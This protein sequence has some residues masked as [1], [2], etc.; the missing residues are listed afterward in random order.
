MKMIVREH[1]KWNLICGMLCPHRMKKIE[2]LSDFTLAKNC[3]KWFIKAF[4][5]VS[6][7]YCKVSELLQPY[8][9]TT[10]LSVRNF[11]WKVTVPWSGFFEFLAV[12]SWCYTS[13]RGLRCTFLTMNLWTKPSWYCCFTWD[14]NEKL[15]WF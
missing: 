3:L 12:A 4:I 5:L 1:K 10:S 2:V 6:S 15:Y 8:N 11:C 7:K 9:L 14:K 13:V